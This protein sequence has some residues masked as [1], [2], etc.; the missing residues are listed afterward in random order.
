M[1]AT[2]AIATPDDVTV[3]LKPQKLVRS[4]YDLKFEFSHSTEAG[5]FLHL[6]YNTDLF[7]RSTIE[8]LQRQLEY[9]IAQIVADSSILGLR[10][11]TDL[12]PSQN[13]DDMS[14]VL[15]FEISF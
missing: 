14:D 9:K 13:T 12:P 6:E 10:D 5:I 8:L 1:G 2:P 3:E 4:L 15:D 11:F 7:E